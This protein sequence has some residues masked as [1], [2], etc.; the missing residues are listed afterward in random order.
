MRPE[1]DGRSFREECIALTQLFLVFLVIIRFTMHTQM[2]YTHFL[3]Q[4]SRILLVFTF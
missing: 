2:Y 4:V 3:R 1:S